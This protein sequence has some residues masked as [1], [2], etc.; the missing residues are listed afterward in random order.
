MAEVPRATEDCGTKNG[1]S[2]VPLEAYDHAPDART[3]STASLE[4][5]REFETII[6]RKWFLI[7]DPRASP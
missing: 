4:N 6:R 7:K 1:S 3:R 5:R 2:D